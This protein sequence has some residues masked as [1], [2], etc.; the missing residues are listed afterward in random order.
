MHTIIVEPGYNDIVLWDT[1]TIDLDILW[2]QLIFVLLTVTFY[3]SVITTLVYNN[4][5]L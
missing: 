3:Y 5:R 1:S 2:L 4:T